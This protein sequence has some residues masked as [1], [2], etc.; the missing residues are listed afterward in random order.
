MTVKRLSLNLC[1]GVRRFY[2]SNILSTFSKKLQLLSLAMEIKYSKKTCILKMLKFIALC[3]VLLI[4]LSIP[5][6]YHFVLNEN[7]KIDSTLAYDGFSLLVSAVL[8][9]VLSVYSTK[10]KL[11]IWN[12]KGNRLFL[13]PLV[14]SVVLAFIWQL[15]TIIIYY[16]ST[17]SYIHKTLSLGISSVLIHFASFVLLG[18]V[19]EELIFRKW[20]IDM[21][22]R[23]GFSKMCVIIVGST[24]FFCLHIGGD[25]VRI[26]T[27]IIA[28][29][30]CIIYIKTHDV[31]YCIITHIANNFIAFIF[32]LGLI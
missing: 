28:I 24:L 32:A 2:L 20:F 3:A 8:L 19:M 14:V 12:F 15:L 6:F 4:S 7:S 27:L 9:L 26:D 25:I 30:L 16:L 29:P 21:M 17:G 10:E 5:Y 23:G 31:R 11:H 1:E 22:E 13:K 18:P